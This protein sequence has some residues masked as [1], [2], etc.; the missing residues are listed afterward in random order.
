MTPAH[1]VKASWVLRM[2]FSPVICPS[3]LSY[4]SGWSSP[5]D[6]VQSKLIVTGWRLF[7]IN[8]YQPP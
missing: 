5:T 8:L 7:P 1:G 2:T 3:L 6:G 4:S